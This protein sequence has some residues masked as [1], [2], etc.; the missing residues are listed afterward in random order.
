MGVRSSRQRLYLHP[1]WRKLLQIAAQF[2]VRYRTYDDQFALESA[3]F[4]AIPIAVYNSQIKGR[5][6]TAFSSTVRQRTESNDM[7]ADVP[8]KRFSEITL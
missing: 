8:I 3:Q 4:T 6:T 2:S 7:C 1:S 5:R